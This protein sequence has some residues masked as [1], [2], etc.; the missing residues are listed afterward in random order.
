[1]AELVFVATGKRKNAIARVRLLPGTG[2]IIVNGKNAPDYFH[3]LTSILL[4]EQPL[5]LTSNIGRFDIIANV[6]GGG[7]SG[8]AGALRHGITR[9]L[10][11]MDAGLRPV[12]KKAGLVTR[13]SRIKERKKYG[14]AGARRAYQFSKR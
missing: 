6:N 1:M 12:L 11:I 13:D 9:A 8:Q 7:L 14:L 5:E 4:I 3:R 10:L 2:K